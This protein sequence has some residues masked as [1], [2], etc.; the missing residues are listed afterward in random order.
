MAHQQ[1]TKTFENI[2]PNKAPQ[3]PRNN[4]ANGSATFV[5]HAA[6]VATLAV[7]AWGDSFL[8]LYINPGGPKTSKWSF[9]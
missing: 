4:S 9:R 7:I 6:K 1:P 2:P 8:Y 3:W 5:V